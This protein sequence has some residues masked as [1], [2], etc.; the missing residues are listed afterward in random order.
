MARGGHPGTHEP[1]APPLVM[2]EARAR[3]GGGPLHPWLP[4]GKYR[5]THLAFLPLPALSIELFLAGSLGFP[6][7]RHESCCP[8]RPQA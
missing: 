7:G 8:P 4:V 3:D 5:G 1:A 2:S 6:G